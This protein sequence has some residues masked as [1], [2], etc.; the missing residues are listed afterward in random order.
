MRCSSRRLGAAH[1]ALLNCCNEACRSLDCLSCSE[2]R[3]SQDL[4]NWHDTAAADNPLIHDPRPKSVAEDS[5]AASCVDAAVDK[6]GCM[7]GKTPFCPTYFTT[8][9]WQPFLRERKVDDIM[10]ACS[11][12]LGESATCGVADIFVLRGHDDCLRSLFGN[13]SLCDGVRGRLSCLRCSLAVS[14]SWSAS[15]SVVFVFRLYSSCA[16]SIIPSNAR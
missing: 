14:S 1:I 3:T 2:K 9:L 16:D 11:V 12:L 5:V 4:P 7:M 15:V 10:L 6:I 13:S 8:F